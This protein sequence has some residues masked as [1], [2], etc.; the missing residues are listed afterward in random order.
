MTDDEIT[1]NLL[2]FIA[3]GHETTAL[4][5]AWTFDLLSRHPECRGTRTIDEI[6]TCN[7][8]RPTASRSISAS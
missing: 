7:R 1:D 6:E 2:T 5:L 4:G 3:A 8:R